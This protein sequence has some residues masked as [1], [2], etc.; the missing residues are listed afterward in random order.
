MVW[1]SFNVSRIGA[2]LMEDQYADIVFVFHFCIFGIRNA[3]H[4]S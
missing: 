4:L 1:G 3:I 2:V